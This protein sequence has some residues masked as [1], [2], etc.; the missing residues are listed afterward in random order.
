MF[1]QSGHGP[2]D[3]RWRIFGISVCIKF[4]FWVV[5][6]LL[7]LYVLELDWGRLGVWVG[8]LLVSDL[9]HELAH[10]IVGRLFGARI[11]IVIGAFGGGLSGYEGLKRWQRMVFFAVG[12][13][14]SFALYAGIEA[15]R[16]YGNPFAWGPNAA[17][18]ILRVVL[19]GRYLV[20]FKACIN[21]LPIYPMDGG[22]VVREICLTVS[23]RYGLLFSL[24]VSF[25][26]ASA[27]A[28]FIGMFFWDAIR[29]RHILACLFFGFEVMLAFQNLLLLIG[30]WRELPSREPPALE[31]DFEEPASTHR[32]HDDYRPFDGGRPQDTEKR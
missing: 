14:A 3:L 9:V 16:F 1:Q 17:L 29:Q 7:G 21:V 15:Y 5:W 11:S 24:L 30:A 28:A 6:L 26:C 13:A 8:V 22:M 25:V 12:P 27:L 32:D 4:S 2:L 20:L 23:R 19:L 18:W 10:A 31:R